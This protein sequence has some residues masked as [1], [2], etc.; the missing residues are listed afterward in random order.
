M[1]TFKSIL[2][3][4]LLVVG[5]VLFSTSCKKDTPA[6]LKILDGKFA[7]TFKSPNPLDP[8]EYPLSFSFNT[9]NTL[10]IYDVE[11]FKA[12]SGSWSV[13]ANVVSGEFSY[14]TTPNTKFLFT[15]I[16]NPK[17]G[18]LSNG[19]W[20]FKPATTGSATFT[21][22][23]QEA[24]RYEGEFVL[25]GSSGIYPMAMELYPDNSLLY[26]ENPLDLKKPS[27][28]GTYV[29]VNNTMFAANIKYFASPSTTFAYTATKSASA[30]SSGSWGNFPMNTG[31]GTYT[32]TKK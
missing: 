24:E 11:N 17:T 16:F 26:F 32:V 31:Y 7:G 3:F 1:K 27:G 18:V 4:T 25:D 9:D 15:A 13:N 23:K 14:D 21:V 19:S 30:L 12:A 8:T 6:P 28:S 5:F 22:T 10:I 29:V 2:A 20:G